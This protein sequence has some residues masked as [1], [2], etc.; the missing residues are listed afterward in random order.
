M[1]GTDGPSETTNSYM[2]PPMY[3]GTL[4]VSG[5]LQIIDQSE[6]ICRRLEYDQYPELHVYVICQRR[7]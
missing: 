3:H 4:G 7:E 2:G 1:G 5:A 6:C